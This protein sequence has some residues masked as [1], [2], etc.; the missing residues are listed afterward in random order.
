MRDLRAAG[1]TTG[2]VTVASASGRIFSGLVI[3]DCEEVSDLVVVELEER[4]A[5]L[6]LFGGVKEIVNDSGN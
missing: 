5:E 1:H 6:S 3:R 2:S 4:D